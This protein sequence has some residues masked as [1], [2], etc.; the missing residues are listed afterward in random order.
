MAWL[1]WIFCGILGAG[2]G[3]FSLMHQQQI[4][5]LRQRAAGVNREQAAQCRSELRALEE[6]LVRLDLDLARETA[7]ATEARGALMKSRDESEVL[8]ARLAQARSELESA[9]AQT[10]S[11]NQDSGM[12]SDTLLRDIKRLE[13]DNRRL[14]AG[15]LTLG[16]ATPGGNLP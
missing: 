7:A 15:L 12:D 6:S 5:L 11:A 2:I 1:G 9:A 16:P 13:N 10:A 3:I 4:D 14:R 8:A